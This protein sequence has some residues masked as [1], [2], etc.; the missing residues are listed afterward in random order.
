MT[1]HLTPK[2]T[3]TRQRIVE[4]AAAEIREHG[5]LVTTLD[6]VLA[7]THTS[8]SQLFHYFPGGKESL[9]LAVAEYEAD[10]V[11]S[12]QRPELD[13]LTSWPAWIAWRD[14][15]LDRYERQGS[16]CPLNVLVTQLGRSTPATQAVVSTLMRR[17]QAG[18][19][20][21]VRAMQALGE[22]RADLDVDHAAAGILAGVQGGVLIML[23]TGRTDHLAAALD[24][25][26]AYLRAN[27]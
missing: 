23:S 12:D 9:L 15:V 10:Q 25:G 3:A 26:I 19:A 5:V 18:I 14:T 17:W 16:H 13:N 8:K 11:I 6:D 20:A 1:R 27:R 22:I 7:R 24:M 4:G 2:G 21:G